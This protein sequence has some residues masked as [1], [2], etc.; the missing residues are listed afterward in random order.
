MVET[1]EVVKVTNMDVS[2]Y[3]KLIHSFLSRDID[4]GGF[5]HAYSTKFKNQKGFLPENAYQ[6]LD[7]L[8]S[9]VD[10]FCADASLCGEE[11]LNEEQLRERCLDAVKK[12]EAICGPA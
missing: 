2:D 4:A 9:D 5:E 12:L 6:I 1:S 7:A 11:D 10:A 3:L 8:F